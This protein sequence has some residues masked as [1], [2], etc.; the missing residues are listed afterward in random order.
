MSSTNQHFIIFPNIFTKGI[1]PW[2]FNAKQYIRYNWG[3]ECLFTTYMDEESLYTEEQK[4]TK[5][6]YENI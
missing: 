5:K 3:V 2:V 1:R 4:L 6:V